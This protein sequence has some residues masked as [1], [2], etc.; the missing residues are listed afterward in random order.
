[1]VIHMMHPLRVAKILMDYNVDAIT[2]EATLLHETV[3]HAGANIDDIKD[4]FGEE[5][6]M[7]VE[8][9]SKLMIRTK[10]SSKKKP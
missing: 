8:T 6:A 7:I 5:V 3:N 10:T 4:K 1:M 9:I 2:I